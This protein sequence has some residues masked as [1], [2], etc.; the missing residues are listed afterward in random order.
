MGNKKVRIKD[1]S[2]TITGNVIIKEVKN[3]VVLR[4]KKINNN[5]TKR[6]LVGI[7]KFLRGDFTNF[8]SE[9]VQYLPLYMGVGIAVSPEEPSLDLTGLTSELNLG[10]R[11]I[12]TP[13]SITVET[14]QIQ[15]SLSAFIPSSLT[16]NN[17]ITEVGLFS[18]KI[19][20]SGG[21]LAKILTGREE[22]I[23]PDTSWLIEWSIILKI[24]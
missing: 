17:I 16:G 1:S 5:V 4:E 8:A 23:E 12:V 3:G 18:N 10:N 22:R 21:L 15:L 9:S 13:G 11:F 14:A 2:T 19:P 7:A 20:L 6:L 24:A